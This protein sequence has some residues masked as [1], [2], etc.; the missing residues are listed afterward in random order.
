MRLTP[1]L[2][3]AVAASFALLAPPKNTAASCWSMRS[4]MKGVSSN[5]KATRLAG[6]KPVKRRLDNASAS[7]FSYLGTHSN[8]KSKRRDSICAAASMS[9]KH[10]G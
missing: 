3:F 5:F 10:N 1:L 9:T 2:A 6:L 8:S 7:A 4:T